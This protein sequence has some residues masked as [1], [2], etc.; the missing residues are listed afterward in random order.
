MMLSYCTEDNNR[1]QVKLKLLRRGGGGGDDNDPEN[2][3][4][5]NEIGS[6]LLSHV[7][8]KM[9]LNT[10]NGGP[11]VQVLSFTFFSLRKLWTQLDR[12]GTD[13]LLKM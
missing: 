3:S 1:Q 12:S 11:F 7:Q 10:F 9:K 8:S 13:L 6:L 5:V 4:E 2:Q